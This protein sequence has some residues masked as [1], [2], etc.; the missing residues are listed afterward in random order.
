MGPAPTHGP[1]IRAAGRSAA[2]PR[3]RYRR[4]WW[5][6]DRSP[7]VPAASPAAAAAG[8]ADHARLAAGAARRRVTH[9][10]ELPVGGH[11]RRRRTVGG[12]GGPAGNLWA[13][14]LSNGST[15][16]G[17]AGPHRRCPHR[18][19]AVGHTRTAAVPT[20]CSSAPATPLSPP[21]AGTTPSP[22]PATELWGQN[23]RRSQ[24][25]TRRAGVAGGGQSRRRQRRGG[26]LAGPGG[27]RL[28]RLHRIVA[29]RM[30]VLHRRQRAS[31]PRR[32][33]TSTAT[34]RPR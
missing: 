12:R 22:T 14:H 9:R 11:P 21:W 26:P 13:F 4:R 10:P 6:R 31:P 2:L 18:L 19:D 29:P 8:G 16:P 25:S 28:R 20:T 5:W 30:A 7:S 34:G 33:P 24:R 32:S 23:G 27:V 17:L 3:R 15:V 1:S